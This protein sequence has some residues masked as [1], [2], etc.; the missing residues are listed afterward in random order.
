MISR[1]IIK[2][3]SNTSNAGLE[4]EYSHKISLKNKLCGDK[5]TLELVVLK[6][7]IL[8]MKYETESC[9]YC[10]ASAS[11]LS[12]KIKKFNIQNIKNEFRNLK[13]SFKKKELKIPK[14]FADYKKLLDSDNLNRY[15]CIF[16]PFDAV[17]KALKL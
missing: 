16:L 5:I 9:V 7:K 15:N 2:I 8:S 10:E 1:E 4:N 14:K 3:A 17:I 13:N 12:K 6:N 11:L